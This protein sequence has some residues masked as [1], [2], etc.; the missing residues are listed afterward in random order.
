MTECKIC[1]IISLALG[2]K[3]M[4]PLL[5]HHYPMCRL[6]DIKKDF[7]DL[8]LHVVG[9]LANRGYTTND[10]DVIGDRADIPALVSRLEKDGI[11]EPI[12]YCGSEHGKH[13]HLRCAY[14][15]IK[16]ALTG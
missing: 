10:I 1:K 2:K 13:S 14:F 15:G 12:H 3:F 4:M 6:A 11:Q 5:G 8:D 9:G 7:H 16:M